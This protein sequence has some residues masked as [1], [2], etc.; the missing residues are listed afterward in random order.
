MV[1]R[2]LPA[3]EFT[4]TQ[5]VRIWED[6]VTKEMSNPRAESFLPVNDFELCETMVEADLGKPKN[7]YPES[8]DILL[9]FWFSY[10]HPNFIIS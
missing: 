4:R 1:Q 10:F 2:K 8:L 7:S 5:F 6:V 3:Q 9:K